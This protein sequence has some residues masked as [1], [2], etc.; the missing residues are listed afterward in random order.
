[1]TW[2]KVA[3]GLSHSALGC[4]AM[5]QTGRLEEPLRTFFRDEV[6]L[7]PLQTQGA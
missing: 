5:G 7:K 6:S 1:M 3:V 4:I 2:H